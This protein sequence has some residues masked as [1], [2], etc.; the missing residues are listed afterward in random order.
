MTFKL[1]FA[2][3]FNTLG[4]PFANFPESDP[5]VTR[6]N[7]RDFKSNSHGKVFGYILFSLQPLNCSNSAVLKNFRKKILSMC[8]LNDN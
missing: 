7:P 8:L 1:S 6:D 2:C 5:R 4:I 3:Y